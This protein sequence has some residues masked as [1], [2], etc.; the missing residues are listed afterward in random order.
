MVQGRLNGAAVGERI[1]D[2]DGLAPAAAMP[3]ASSRLPAL[4]AGATPRRPVWANSF[5]GQR[6]QDETAATLRSTNTAWSSA[7]G[8]DRKIRPDWLV[9]A[10]IGGGSGRLSVD[11]GSQHVDTD[12]LFTGAYG[13][14]EG[15]RNSSI[16]PC[17]AA[18]LPTSRAGWC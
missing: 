8:I 9:G 6:T 4:P 2:G 12:Y 14:F 15:A 18:A 3:G 1:D 16:S 5:G 7:M 17:R 10:F 11:L 13:R